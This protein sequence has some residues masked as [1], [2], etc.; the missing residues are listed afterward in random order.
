M[1]L[2]K[3]YS[4]ISKACPE[5]IQQFGRTAGKRQN[6]GKIGGERIVVDDGAIPP[7]NKVTLRCAMAYTAYDDGKNKETI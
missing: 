4:A 5:N 3:T 7:Y 2:Q 6:G 1:Y